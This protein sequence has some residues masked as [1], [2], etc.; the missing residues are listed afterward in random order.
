MD[1][2][3]KFIHKLEKDEAL[4]VLTI[5]ER[6]RGNDLQNLDVKK[7]KGKVNEYRVRIGK[8][9]IQFRKS[10]SGN[11]ITYLGNRDDNTY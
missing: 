3:D 7:L 9:R 2:I 6:I 4:H 1:R 11:Q 10:D 8:R 5:M